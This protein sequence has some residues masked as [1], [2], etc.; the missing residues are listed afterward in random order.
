MRKIPVFKIWDSYLNKKLRIMKN[1]KFINNIKTILAG[2]LFLT[3]I[4]I[5]WYF[6]NISSTK[7]FFIKQENNKL[8]EIK[9]QNEI[10]RIDIEKYKSELSQN[11]IA[12]NTSIDMSTWKVININNI[13]QLTRLP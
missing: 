1:Y 6:V 2:I 7:W 12:K 8:S 4:S 3:S 13:M 10:V 9:F 5:Y 11:I